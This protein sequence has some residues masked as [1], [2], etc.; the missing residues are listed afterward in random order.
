MSAD[1]LTA[2]LDLLRRVL[3]LEQRQGYRNNSATGGVY[4]YFQEQFGRHDYDA[5]TW[6]AVESLLHGLKRYEMAPST[7][8]RHVQI[9]ILLRR[10]AEV[11][12]TLDPSPSRGEGSQVPATQAPAAGPV[13]AAHRGDADALR[14]VRTPPHPQ[15]LSLAG[16]RGVEAPADP[17]SY[18]SGGK[19]PAVSVPLARTDDVTASTDGTTGGRQDAGA[20]RVQRAASLDQPLGEAIKM[21]T[22]EAEKLE[23]LGVRTVEQA[24]YYFPRDH[25]DCRNPVPINR[26]RPGMITTLV[27]VLKAVELRRTA[28][29]LTLVEARIADETAMI[30]ITWFSQYMAALLRP[31]IGQRIAVSGHAEIVSGRLQFEPRDYEFPDEDELTHTSGLVPIYPLTEGLTQRW[32]RGAIKRTLSAALHLVADPLEAALSRAEHPLYDLLHAYDLPPL[33]QALSA[34]HFPTDEDEKARAIHRLAFDELLC[35]G[36]GMEQRKLA[37]QQGAPAHPVPRDAETLGRFTDALPFQLTGAQ[38]RALD[39]IL[40]DMARSIP[41]SRLL[42]GDVGSGKTVVAAAAL[43]MAAASGAQGAIMAPT[44]I[45]AEQHRRSMAPLLAPF[46][47]EVALL[48]GSVKGAERK[49][50]Y[51]GAADGSIAV[52][53]GTHALIQEGVAFEKIGLVVVDEQHRFGVEQRGRLRQKGFNPHVLAMTATPIPRTLTHTIHGDLDVSVIDERPPGRQPVETRWEASERGAFALVRSEVAQ[54]RQAFIICP[55][56]EESDKLEAKAAVA[57]HKRLQSQVFPD[58]SVGLLHGKMKPSEKEATLLR[59]RD[60]E[61]QVLVATS[62]V[63][64]GIDVPNATVMVV[65]EANRFG[66]A[67]LHQFR[68]RVGRGAAR[69]YC[70]LLAG[71]ASAAGQQRLS[72]LVG[73]DDGFKLAEE[74]LRLRGPGDFLGTRQSGLPALQVAGLGDMRSIEQ[75]REAARRLI[76]ADP[77]LTQPEHHLLAAKVARFWSRESELS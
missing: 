52:L 1:G 62:V 45:L 14:R 10:V 9:E 77:A 15:P 32:L 31:H 75:A 55:L 51:A 7:Q 4:R 27:G 8:D 49:R 46:G 54:G 29:K 50:V 5:A 68:G 47:C 19:A 58:L 35:V 16:E 72:A 22:Q 37:W 67:Q 60:G 73:T 74:D 38:R 24:L 65:E 56:V 34:Y 63:E 26:L 42:Q 53:V 23:R 28:R 2:T 71:S 18:A 12:L 64:V 61:I 48:T 13:S 30:R 3:A 59:F 39:A 6:A 33:R 36:I 41:M 40:G 21:R 76:G 69:S 44:E 70:I 57:E 66:L 17:L 43:L 25:Y 20:P 11:P